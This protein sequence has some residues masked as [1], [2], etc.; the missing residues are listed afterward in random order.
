MRVPALLLATSIFLCVLYFALSSGDTQA[1]T[2][3][4][5]VTCDQ[6]VDPKDVLAILTQEGGIELLAE[7][8]GVSGDVNCDGSIDEIDA[9]WLLALLAGIPFEDVDD[10]PVVGDALPA[11]E[12]PGDTALVVEIA[13]RQDCNAQ[14]PQQVV[15]VEWEYSNPPGPIDV[16]ID[17]VFST[18]P[19]QTQLH[20]SV[21]GAAEFTIPDEGPAVV[22]ITVTISESPLGGPE[23]ATN[24]QIIQFDTCFPPATPAP[25]GVGFVALPTPGPPDP[26]LAVPPGDI[27]ETDVVHLGGSPNGPTRDVS[28]VSVGTGASWTMFSYTTD[29]SSREPTQ[30]GQSA[31][32]GGHSVKLLAL[33]PRLSPKLEVELLVAAYINEGNLWLSTWRIE[34]SGNFTLLGRRGFGENAGAIVERYG[35]AHR[36]VPASGTPT[37]FQVVTPVIAD[38]VTPQGGGDL[39]DGIRTVTWSVNATTGAVNGLHDVGPWDSANPEGDPAISHLSG[40][41]VGETVYVVNFI[42]SSDLLAN[43]YWSVSDG[44]LASPHGVAYTGGDLQ[45]DDTVTQSPTH[46]A[47]APL[48]D[49]GF[50]TAGWDSGLDFLSTWETAQGPCDAGCTFFPNE[51]SNQ[52]LDDQGGAGVDV[53]STYLP[54][55]T[56]GSNNN[57]QGGAIQPVRAI[58]TDSEWEEFGPGA[59]QVFLQMPA[60][61]PAFPA[62]GIASVGKTM[63][64]LLVAEAIEA[65]DV[66]LGTE[67]TATSNGINAGGSMMGLSV[68]ETHTLSNLLWGMMIPSGNDAAFTIGESIAGSVQGWV[69]MMNA[70]AAE[71]NLTQT[72]YSRPSGGAYSTPQEQ[73]TV[74][75]EGWQHEVFR[76]YTGPTSVVACGESATQD[77]VC[78]FYTKNGFYP[79]VQGWKGGSTGFSIP[80]FAA[81][82]VPLCTSCRLGSAERMGRQMVVAL[83]QTGAATGDMVELLDYGYAQLF[84]PDQVGPTTI[85]SGADFGLDG[86]SDGLLITSHINNGDLQVCTW[87]MFLDLGQFDKVDCGEPRVPTTMP[88]GI[89][90]EPTRI[91]IARISTL[92]YEGDYV[93]GESIASQFNLKMWRVGPKEP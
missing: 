88:G 43:A 41:F 58:L 89:G 83:Q 5:D 55:L 48:A 27:V 19:M 69:D 75:L 52:T 65:G 17:A 80:S 34:E 70:K 6:V 46:V 72:I 9:L 85:V 15:R 79:G 1:D 7:C 13:T 68:G 16:T 21:D 91:D 10:C 71:L 29:P 64:L 35:I 86:I 31:L 12:E 63:T 28:V 53:D 22:T 57:V 50:I 62:V 38:Q 73:V 37:S 3:Q 44:G 4:G 2:I 51:M 40:E 23:L 56:N 78:Y 74:W 49:G 59:G 82:G 33:S 45:S 90:P 67:M 87:D 24:Q 20:D 92:L 32:F 93:T 47:S 81:Q 60:I 76:T 84:T 8:L 66:T 61:P 18:A 11:D 36:Q 14:V 54:T 25:A 26:P 30:I 77:E 42:H 39:V